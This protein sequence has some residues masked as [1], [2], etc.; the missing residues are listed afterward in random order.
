MQWIAEG[1]PDMDDWKTNIA[2]SIDFGA[3]AVYVQGV[4][5]DQFYKA[6]RLDLLGKCVEFIKGRGV[7]AGSE[8][9]T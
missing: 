8:P 9:Q 7:R 2:E 6:G 4:K 5:A 1:H 3:A